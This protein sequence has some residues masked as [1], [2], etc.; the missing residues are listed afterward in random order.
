MALPRPTFIDLGDSRSPS[1]MSIKWNPD[2]GS[3]RVQ[4]YDGD[5]PPALS[6]LDAFAAH[7]RRLARELEET[8]KAGERRMS[9]LPP[10]HIT[11]S[12]TEHKENRPSI[13]RQLSGQEDVVPPLPQIPKQSSGNAPELN[14]P[15]DR[16][17]SSYPRI[18]AVPDEEEG[19]ETETFSTPRETS[20]RRS[21]YFGIPRS[22]S[23]TK[24]DRQNTVETSP[25]RK[26]ASE[27]VPQPSTPSNPDLTFTLAPPNAAF[28]RRSYHESSEDE[29]TNSNAGSTFSKTRKLS[30]SSGVSLPQ[31]PTSPYLQTFER[32][33]SISSE[34]SQTTPGHKNRRSHT[35][36][37]RPMSSSSLNN[38]A[39]YAH[40]SPSRQDSTASQNSR[41]SQVLP[42]LPTPSNSFDD[43]RSAN[44]DGFVG[45]SSSYTHATYTLPRGRK[46]DRTSAM[47]SGIS[48][49]DFQWQEPMFP[50]TP[51][52][53]GRPSYDMPQPSPD[54]LNRP[55]ADVPSRSEFSFEFQ[56]NR[57]RPFANEGKR[58]SSS[59]EAKKPSLS[60]P[61]TAV[62][63]S[64]SHSPNTAPFVAPPIPPTPVDQ[65]SYVESRSNST[66]RPTTARSNSDYQALSP[67]EHV[68]KAIH[69]HEHGDLK[70]STYHLRIA[71]K[72]NHPTGMLLY[73]LACRHGW[74][75]RQ[76]PKEGVQWLRK[77]VDLAQ[78]EVAEDEAPSS[79]RPQPDQSE[80]KAHRAQF[81]LSIYELGQCH[82]NGWGMEQDKALA[83]RCFEIAGNWGDTDA[84]TE[85]G[86]CYAEGIGC[87]KDLKK[88][89]KWYREA[90]KKGVN[91][92]GNSW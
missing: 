86:F 56:Q 44:S 51:P 48:G 81:A 85:A 69:L 20:N 90:E 31:W 17:Q 65:T 67:D 23:P 63:P 3:P 28:A 91:M 11:Q 68:A 66:I 14:E 60:P 59:K 34:Y 76:S 75:M 78:L 18:S 88:A 24:L 72:H 46:A 38:L 27:P 47:F 70:E 35:N 1:A 33:P 89:A 41:L 74:G 8:R 13:F 32:S 5:V 49:P 54:A 62:R 64:T 83:L 87:K 84:L 82:L 52:L 26:S 55:S 92:V 2:D 57:P 15:K 29:C 45:Q 73:A 79:D 10:Q 43:S 50:G 58:P 42:A 25:Q 19:K 9:R 53:E 7:S 22:E 80:K 40:L 16:P 30:S 21:G 12:L 39:Q 6:P 77:A 37:S 4:H 61:T 36:F 71:A